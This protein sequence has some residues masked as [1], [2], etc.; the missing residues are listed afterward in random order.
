MDVFRDVV[1]SGSLV[2]LEVGGLT[3]SM[4]YD[5]TVFVPF[6]VSGTS[7]EFV[8]DIFTVHSHTHTHIHVK[9]RG[10]KR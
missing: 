9:I 8:K 7:D 2:E 3:T 1:N 10:K 5:W 6:S 4:R